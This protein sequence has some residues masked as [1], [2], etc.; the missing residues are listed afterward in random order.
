M[1]FNRFVKLFANIAASRG[2]TK[3]ERHAIRSEIMAKYAIKSRRYLPPG[4]QGEAVIFS[5]AQD[6]LFPEAVAKAEKILVI[7]VPEHNE[8][9]GGVYS[10]YSIA[11]HLHRFKSLHGY[12]V[13]VMTRPNV[14]GLTFLRQTCFRNSENVFR[15]EQLLLCKNARDI[16]MH[17]PEYATE[18]LAGGLTDQLRKFFKN[19]GTLHIN[20]LNQN[21]TF[22]PEREKF[23][24]LFEIADEVTQSVAHHSYC[25]QEHADKYGIPSLLLPAYTDLSSYT[26]TEFDE[27]ED[28]IIYSPDEADHKDAILADIREKLPHYELVEIRGI[29]FD[30]FMDYATRC[31]FSI[32]FGE[33][34]DGYMAQP[35]HMGGMGLTA[36][37]DEFFPSPHFKSYKNVFDDTADMTKRIVDTIQE[38]G[39]NEAAY[40]E[41]NRAFV[42]EYDKLYS[43]EDYL[44][45][46]KK[47]AL[48]EFEIFPNSSPEV[49]AKRA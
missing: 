29:S 4:L 26:P 1:I 35:I 9:S 49:R 14:D 31:R 44:D 24:S 13:I 10:M 20:I 6:L 2:K 46:I 23:E 22:M 18:Y 43:K 12:E 30:T 42:A 7:V 33:G 40:A 37:N 39:T 16:Y 8:M 36:Y 15:F 38:L 3:V 25:T 5:E 34:F 19:L 27:K 45:R 11:N 41:L 47:L 21:I 48:K 32:S 28:L 17:V